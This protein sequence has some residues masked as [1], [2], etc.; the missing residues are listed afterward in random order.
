MDPMHRST[1]PNLA[2]FGSNL[3]KHCIFKL[4]GHCGCRSSM[5]RFLIMGP[6]RLLLH[7]NMLLQVRK[8][9]I[10]STIGTIKKMIIGLNIYI[11]IYI[12]CFKRK[13]ILYSSNFFFSQILFRREKKNKIQQLKLLFRKGVSYL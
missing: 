13:L 4:I 11:Y 2:L 12:Y 5:L 8:I 7:E 9:S 1:E 10:L 3:C 6:Q